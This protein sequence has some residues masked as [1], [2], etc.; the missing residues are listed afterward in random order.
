MNR[1]GFLG[2]LAA[3]P[4][5]GVA[6]AASI[7]KPRVAG[8]ARELAIGY[9]MNPRRTIQPATYKWGEW[10]DGFAIHD[11]EFEY[12]GIVQDALNRNAKRILD[13][14]NENCA[15]LNKLKGAKS[16]AR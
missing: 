13:H 1:R 5:A 2:A 11:S 14:I 16:W 6:V 3:L 10:H 7:T 9:G 4:V 8:K 15:L 12:R